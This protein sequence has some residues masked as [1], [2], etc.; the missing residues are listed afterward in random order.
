MLTGGCGM[1]C[2]GMRDG[3]GGFGV[4][5]GRGGGVLCNE[6]G[7]LFLLYGSSAVA[8]PAILEAN[9]AH[10]AQTAGQRITD[11]NRRI[12]ILAFPAFNRDCSASLTV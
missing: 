2:G 10:T 5:A 3:G 4:E 11:L 12:F 8:P 7:T 1:F 9:K 6:D